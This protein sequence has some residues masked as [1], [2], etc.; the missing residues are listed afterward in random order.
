MLRLRLTASTA[1]F[2]LECM[3]GHVAKCVC[4]VVHKLIVGQRLWGVM[5]LSDVAWAAAQVFRRV[6]S[7]A[8]MHGVWRARLRRRRWRTHPRLLDH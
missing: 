3:G 5:R 4:V 1:A 8:G 7:D 2:L 6:S